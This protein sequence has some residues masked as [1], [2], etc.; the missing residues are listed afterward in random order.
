[1]RATPLTSDLHGISMNHGY[2]ES[3]DRC[4]KPRQSYGDRSPSAVHIYPDGWK[5]GFLSP[6]TF[7][8]RP[9]GIHLNMSAIFPQ[10]WVF[11]YR[12]A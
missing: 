5:N 7:A 10:Y 3:Q 1:M 9:D 12:V 11:L 6:I 4:R 2:W 8:L